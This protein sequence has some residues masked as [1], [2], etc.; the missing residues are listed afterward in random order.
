VLW[1]RDILVWYGSGSGR[2]Y[3]S[4]R[5][6][7]IGS[8]FDKMPTKK[9]FFPSFFVQYFFLLVDGRIRICTNNNGSTTLASTL[10]PHTT[11]TEPSPWTH[12]YL[13]ATMQNKMPAFM[14]IPDPEFFLGSRVQI[15]KIYN[16]LDR[17]RK[18]KN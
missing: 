6:S 2:P 1:I 13:T 18:E 7:V 9:V 3:P 17:Y 14:F 4:L 12:I 15:F 5:D 10:D 11:K 16:F 8:S